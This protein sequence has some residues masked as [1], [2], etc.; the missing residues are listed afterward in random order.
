MPV[1]SDRVWGIGLG[2]HWDLVP[3]AKSGPTKAKS[4]LDVTLIDEAQAQLH[5]VGVFKSL[6]KTDAV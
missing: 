1:K 2:G 6:V 4:G 5:N 3:K